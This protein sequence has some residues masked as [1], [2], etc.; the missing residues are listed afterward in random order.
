MR[1]PVSDTQST[2]H[3]GL[4]AGSI[5]NLIHES[6]VGGMPYHRDC[7]NDR[8]GSFDEPV[9]PSFD[10]R[11]L[12]L[13][14]RASERPGITISPHDGS[15]VLSTAVNDAWW[16]AAAKCLNGI[17]AHCG[18]AM[19]IEHGRSVRLYNTS[20]GMTTVY[21]THQCCISSFMIIG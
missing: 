20:N 14:M 13:P 15:I 18:A 6:W 3:V 10:S 11:R 9:L 1:C 19:N 21:Q 7:C 2:H 12:I 5:S 8:L 16:P 17:G 4:I